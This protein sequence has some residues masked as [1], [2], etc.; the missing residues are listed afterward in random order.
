M[1]ETNDAKIGKKLVKWFINTDDNSIIESLSMKTSLLTQKT[2][3]YIEGRISHVWINSRG[4]EKAILDVE[5]LAR[6]GQLIVTGG[7]QKRPYYIESKVDKNECAL[8][9]FYNP[10]ERPGGYALF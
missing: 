7:S 6:C 5:L 4:Y 3:I 9:E 2:I 8:L 1:K 10:P